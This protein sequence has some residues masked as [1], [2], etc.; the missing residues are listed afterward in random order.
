MNRPLKIT[1]V[2][3]S[4]GLILPKDVTSAMKVQK[5]DKVMLS[6][7]PGGGFNLSPYDPEIARQLEVGRKIAKKYRETLRALAK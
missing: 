4:L 2:G 6:E 5:G 1:Q 3:N 7:A